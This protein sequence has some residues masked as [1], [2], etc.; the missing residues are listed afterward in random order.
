[1]T[2][3]PIALITGAS[4]GIGRAAA[5]EAARR[6]MHVVALARST[7]ALEELDDEIR[8]A[9]GESATLITLDLKDLDSIDGLA[10]PLLERFGR[11]DALLANAG[12]LG[13]LGP[14][15]SVSP[16]SFEDTIKIN[17]MANWRLIRALEPLLKAA[18]AGRAV[19]MTSGVVPRP[20]AYWGP[21]QA[22][23]MGLE[24]LVK[25][26][27]DENEHSSLNIN[28]FDP[29]ATATEM[30]FNAMPGEDQSTLPSPE[31]VAAKLVDYLE[32][33]CTLNN[34]R[35]VFGDL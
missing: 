25:A 35:I 11:I 30:R 17:L 16:R 23:K 28:L 14:L 10:A 18:P 26:W 15:Q 3:T 9:T 2:D 5:L 24:G 19:F 20:R 34:A 31:D 4:K 33:G 21:Y 7:K 13:T 6:G 1:M 12:I 22:S 32:P 8:K 27:A 29:G